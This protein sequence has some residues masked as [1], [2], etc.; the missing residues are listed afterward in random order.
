ML[1]RVG[2]LGFLASAVMMLVFAL[3]FLG[4]VR[5][6]TDRLGRIIASVLTT[7]VLIMAFATLIVMGVKVPAVELWRAILYNALALSLL[8]ANIGFIWAQFYA[9]RKTRKQR[10]EEGIR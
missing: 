2:D 3:L 4:S 1:D 8:G 6:W 10:K 7:M 9:P 5:W